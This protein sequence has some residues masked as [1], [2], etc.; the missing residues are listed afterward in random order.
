VHLSALLG[1]TIFE[2]LALHEGKFMCSKVFSHIILSRNHYEITFILI[3]LLIQGFPT[4]IP[5]AHPNSPKKKFCSDFIKFFNE[6]LF[7]YPITPALYV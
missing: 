6:N 7:Q 3:I 2:I 5:R 1:Y 4:T